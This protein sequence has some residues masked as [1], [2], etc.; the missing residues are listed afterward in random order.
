MAR[1]LLASLLLGTTA[2]AQDPNA[3]S[4]RDIEK[5]IRKGSEFLKSAPFNPDRAHPCANDLILLTLIHAEVAEANPVFQQYLKNCVEAPL[6]KTYNVALLAMSLEEMDPTGYQQKLAQCAQFLLDNQA[7]NGQWSYG[8]PTDLKKYPF[9]GKKEDKKVA[10][11]KGGPQPRDFGATTLGPKKKPA[12]AIVVMQSRQTGAGGDNSNSQYA[13]LGL[14]ACHD[15]NITLPMDVLHLARKWW[16]DSQSADEAE[17][18][19]G[20]NAVGTGG[21]VTKVQGW[22]YQ[23]A[24]DGAKAPYHAMT[25]GAVGAVVI[26]DYMIGKDWKKDPVATAGCNWL[27]KHWSV[28]GNLYYM[29]ALERAGMLYG[30]EKFG[31]HDWYLEGAKSIVRS[32][33][34]DGSWGSNNDEEKNTIQTCFAILFLKKATR[35][36]AT[37]DRK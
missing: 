11:G 17:A 4:P 34:A 28:N 33:K 8:R 31:D 15:A 30:T 18:K 12:N 2:L 26:Y 19:A 21:E 1:V 13:S 22:N 32:Q 10:T 37:G 27:G 29:Y 9:E 6:E 35:A 5:A 23:N 20:K 3:V 14:R 25:A 16:I 36:I 7:T 24:S